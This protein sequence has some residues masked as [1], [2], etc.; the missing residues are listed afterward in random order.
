MISFSWILWLWAW[1]SLK[2]A[3]WDR[4]RLWKSNLTWAFS[5]TPSQVQYKLAIW[6]ISLFRFL[7]QVWRGCRAFGCT[8][9]GDSSQSWCEISLRC[10]DLLC[11]PRLQ[12]SSEVVRPHPIPR[13]ISQDGSWY[14]Q[15]HCMPAAGRWLLQHSP[16]SSH[17]LGPAF[18][19][20][21]ASCPS[22]YTQAATCERGWMAGTGDWEVLCWRR[23]RR[24]GG[25][26]LDGGEGRA[27]ERR[28]DRPRHWDK[29]SEV[30]SW[31]KLVFCMFLNK[32]FRIMSGFKNWNSKVNEW[33]RYCPL[34]NI[35]TNK[36]LNVQHVN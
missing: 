20:S 27:M 31:K 2:F 34:L 11:P 24:E 29:A 14:L 12:C 4:I 30:A 7:S 1:V 28:V 18:G 22:A 3:F 19:V 23:E 32:Y 13:G 25:Y 9:V 26:K 5:Q 33:R 15:R 8:L 16:A 36:Y 6:L 10:N 17:D 21:G 35:E